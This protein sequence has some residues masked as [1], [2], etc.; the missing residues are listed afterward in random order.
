MMT[1]RRTTCT[2][3]TRGPALG[4][5]LMVGNFVFISIVFELESMWFSKETNR[6]RRV[7]GE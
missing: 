6:Q 7:K 5:S 1:A 3:R 2:T 4:C